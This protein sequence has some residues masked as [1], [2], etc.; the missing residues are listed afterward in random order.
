MTHE[1]IERLHQSSFYFFAT[2]FVWLLVISNNRHERDIFVNAHGGMAW[3]TC[4]YWHLPQSLNQ[5]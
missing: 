2:K 5:H 3:K 1:C 4:T